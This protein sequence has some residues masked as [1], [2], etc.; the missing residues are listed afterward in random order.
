MLSGIV[1]NERSNWI[2]SNVRY[3]ANMRRNLIDT[4]NNQGPISICNFYLHE[5]ADDRAFPPAVATHLM[6]IYSERTMA[7]KTS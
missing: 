1:A 4:S 7:I 6:A 3:W 2:P 5:T